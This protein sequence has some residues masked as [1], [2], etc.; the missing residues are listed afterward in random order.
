MV[1]EVER[2]SQRCAAPCLPEAP[3]SRHLTR[4]AK[5]GRFGRRL[6]LLHGGEG[7]RDVQGGEPG[8]VEGQGDL[9]PGVID[10]VQVLCLQSG[11]L[12]SAGAPSVTCHS[13]SGD[14]Q[15][16]EKR[17]GRRAG[18]AGYWKYSTVRPSSLIHPG[19]PD[20]PPEVRRQC[21]RARSTVT[22]ALSGSC[23]AAPVIRR[24]SRS[25]CWK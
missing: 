18:G 15:D 25:G 22:S 10:Q 23:Q 6:P 17:W 19:Q 11:V 13:P 4:S 20:L 7:Q 12:V 8:P 24:V 2:H 16:Q 1:T 21:R 5:S 14:R 3:V 9:V